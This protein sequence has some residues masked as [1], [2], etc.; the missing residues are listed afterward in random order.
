MH[1]RHERGYKQGRGKVDEDGIGGDVVDIP[2]EFLGH[3]SPG[4]GRRAYQTYHGPLQHN[5]QS[6]VRQHDEHTSDAG[7]ETALYEQQP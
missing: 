5:A 3:D 2:S 4:C 1:D 7:E 6:A